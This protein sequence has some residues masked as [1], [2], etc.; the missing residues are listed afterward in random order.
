M[1]IPT[2][3]KDPRV[4]KKSTGVTTTTKTS[5]LDSN[6][7]SSAQKLVWG[8][9]TTKQTQAVQNYDAKNGAWA[10]AT[11]L[12]NYNLAKDV[13]G[14]D[15]TSKDVST[16]KASEWTI[17]TQ[18][19]GEKLQAKITKPATI[20]ATATTTGAT[21][22]TQT[23][24]APQTGD[25]LTA[26]NLPAEY[27]AFYDTLSDTEKKQFEAIWENARKAGQDVAK[28]YA[29]YMRDYDTTKKR[30]GENQA[31]TEKQNALSS[32]MQDI[33]DNQTLRKAREQVDKLIQT[34][35]YLGSQWMPWVSQSR[36]TGIKDQINEAERTYSELKD[37]TRLSTSSR[38][39]GYEQQAVEYERQL[40]DLNTKLNDD[41]NI[42]IQNVRNELL[43]ADS[44]GK[45]DTESE[46][47]A[48]RVKMLQD[49]DSK[50]TGISDASIQQR[51]FLIQR[52]DN[53]VQEAKLKEANKL[54]IN[55]E[56]SQL[57]GYYMD[58]NGEPIISA[59]TGQRIQYNQAPIEPI[60]DTA[61]GQLIT[62]SQDANGNIVGKYEQVIPLPTFQESTIAS[63]ANLVAQGKL[64]Y[65]DVPENIRNTDTFINSFASSTTPELIKMGESSLY[66]PVNQR[67]ITP[68]TQWGVIGATWDLRSLASQFPW[69]AWAKNN[70]PAGITWN[71]NF[72]NPI[73]WS[74]AQRLIDA[75]INFSKW[76]SRPASEGGNYV[77]FDTIE[78]GLAAQRIMMSGTYGNS[79]VWQMLQ[80]WVGTS[81]W[82][83]YAKQVAGNAGIDLNT[84][85]SDLS[86]MELW[87]LQMAKIQKE[88][89]W[90]YNLLTQSPKT[91]SKPN[92]SIYRA[93]VEDGKLPSKD[94]LIGM[95]MTSQQFIDNASE[96]YNSYLKEKEQEINSI[97]PTL[98]VEFT[99]SYSTISATQREKV[100]ES[101]KKIWDIDQ[102]I[103]K[104]KSIFE[105]SWTEVLPTKDKAEM[106]SL[107]QQIILKAKEVENLWVLNWPDLWILETLI[108]ETTWLLSG[109]FSFDEN[110]KA[111]LNS[112]QSNYRTDAQTQGINYWV[113][114]WF[115]TPNA[116]TQGEWTSIGWQTYQST[117]WNTYN[118]DDYR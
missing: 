47:E 52:Y 80:K 8:N 15:L 55:P 78:D 32:Q 69:Q 37:L 60:Y 57:Q 93:Y 3:A 31:Y 115:N 83:N 51:Q 34:T 42:A 103:E 41:I 98:N 67:W 38:E 17:G 43:K 112:I 39:A 114:I 117:T 108:P 56:M 49:L 24:Q 100:N 36:I 89:P 97:Y 65:D 23:T 109:L 58:G 79:T 45:L 87:E 20:G 71:A 82:P 10:T 40:E 68:P 4:T 86:D 105:R 64:G 81:E 5:T 44:D 116:Q 19:T 53:I 54:I 9:L 111:K 73:P 7:L 63:F 2:I 99:P 66:D 27:K 88:S 85:V 13:K 107:K 72:D 50:I 21:T 33:Q 14:T 110:T 16:V 113:R 12:A 26:Q 102:R 30:I 90:L 92:L 22:N 77:T 46:I 96:W 6:S 48:F 74:T 84:K 1:A 101:M 91:E 11:K 104:L 61:K 59:T 62:F 29:N 118:L 28:E 94:A 18:A 106:K 75:G 95:N 35:S 70:N 25:V 76:T